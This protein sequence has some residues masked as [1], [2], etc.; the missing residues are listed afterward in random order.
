M[1]KYL[2]GWQAIRREKTSAQAISNLSRAEI[3][4]TAVRLGE[5]VNGIRNKGF[6]PP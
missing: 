4:R 2:A 3:F 6:T 5:N 1:S